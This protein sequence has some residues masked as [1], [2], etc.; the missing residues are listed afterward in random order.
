MHK[1]AVRDSTICVG[2]IACHEGLKLAIR[3]KYLIIN[4]Y[5][6]EV[7]CDQ[8][9]VLVSVTVTERLVGVEVRPPGQTLS[10]QLTRLLDL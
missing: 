3:H 1:F 9:T 4:E 2:V 7:F 10:N 5:S 6:A 8:V